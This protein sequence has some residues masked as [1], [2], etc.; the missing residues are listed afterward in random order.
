MKIFSKILL[1]LILIPATSWGQD[2][3]K[4]YNEQS[5]ILPP[6]P[7]AA[8]LGKYGGVNMNLSSGSIN[9]SVPIFTLTGRNLNLPISISYASNGIKVD[10]IAVLIPPQN[11]NYISQYWESCECE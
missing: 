8:A 7:N 10:E 3:Y 11:H 1:S 2:Y 9:T 5:S 4:D 6:S